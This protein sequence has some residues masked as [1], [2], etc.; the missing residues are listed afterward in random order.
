[1]SPLWGGHLG[2]PL[3]CCPALPVPSGALNTHLGQTLRHGALP[4]WV[5]W[6]H[7]D[8]FGG[9]YLWSERISLVSVS[10]GAASSVLPHH[11]CGDRC[12]V[13]LLRAS[14]NALG[15]VLCL[16]PLL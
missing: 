3:P 9:G 13:S 10:L 1:M 4:Y 6:P 12:R 8:F 7:G 2:S 14:T 15:A 5:L 16:Q 11:V